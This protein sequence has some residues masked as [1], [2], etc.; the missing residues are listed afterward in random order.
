[1]KCMVLQGKTEREQLSRKAKILGE[2]KKFGI[3]T[4]FILLSQKFVKA[5]ILI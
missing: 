2:K 1:M 5:N 3:L 4:D